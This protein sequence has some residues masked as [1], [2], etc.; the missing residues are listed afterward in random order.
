M[1]NKDLPH[2]RPNP[3]EAVVKNRELDLSAYF[4]VRRTSTES[5]TISSKLGPSG[6]PSYRK[7]PKPKSQKSGCS[8]QGPRTKGNS[9][10]SAQSIIAKDQVIRD[11]NDR[12][13]EAT[14]PSSAGCLS[15]RSVDPPRPPRAGYE[16]GWF[17]EGYWAEREIPSPRKAGSR[18][19]W[20]S[21]SPQRKSKSSMKKESNEKTIS[22]TD[23][24]TIKIG[25]LI[26]RRSPASKSPKVEYSA[27]TSRKSSVVQSIKNQFSVQS[28]KSPPEYCGM[29]PEEQLGLYCRAK[30]TVRS[31]FMQKT[32]TVGQNNA[33]WLA[34]C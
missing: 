15:N 2:L 18:Q 3:V 10:S 11:W 32:T 21:R 7:S 24:P 20:W 19:K 8:S 33:V 28:K 30:K 29:T 1:K 17:P 16:W 34:T 14:T 4:L 5:D 26:S 25:S 22:T 23:L 12:T 13:V 9:I 27:S 31:R 6:A